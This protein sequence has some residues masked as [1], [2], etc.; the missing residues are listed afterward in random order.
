M[1]PL[2]TEVVAQSVTLGGSQLEK[3]EHPLLAFTPL[4]PLGHAM[5]ATF[6]A[7]VIG[8]SN[9]PRSVTSV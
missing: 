2:V 8:H 4:G 7:R 1:N 6:P 9:R 3:I 5:V